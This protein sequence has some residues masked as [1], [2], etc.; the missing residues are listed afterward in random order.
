MTFVGSQIAIDH[1]GCR[2]C[3]G[4]NGDHEGDGRYVE[5]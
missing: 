4:Q 3:A 1:G 2:K 5:R